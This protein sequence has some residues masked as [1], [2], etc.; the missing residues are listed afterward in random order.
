MKVESGE[1]KDLGND[2]AFH[3]DNSWQE[4]SVAFGTRF[5]PL[6]FRSGPPVVDLPC[7]MAPIGR[8]WGTPHHSKQRLIFY[9]L[10]TV[11]R[12]L[13]RGSHPQYTMDMIPK[14]NSIILVFLLL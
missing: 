12:N 3:I 2:I 6:R 11:G 5:P 1:W 7:G 8:K 13:D 4:K 14:K 9:S 10:Y